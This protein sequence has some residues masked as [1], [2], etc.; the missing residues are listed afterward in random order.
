MSKTFE[1]NSG[2]AGDMDDIGR[3][4]Q[5]AG[6]R[7]TIPSERLEK[8]RHR[9]GAHWEQVVAEQRRGGMTRFR[10]VAVAAS[11]LVAVAASFL[12]WRAGDAPVVIV[13]ASID[14]V[15]GE[16]LVA[17]QVVGKGD[18][19]GVDTLIATGP[20]SRIALRMAGGQSLRI[21]TS[22]QLLVHSSNHVFLQASG[23]YIDTD[24]ALNPLP[25]MVSTPLGVA[26]DVGTQFQVR[27]AASVLMVGVRDGV[28]EVAQTGQQSLSVNKDRFVELDMNGKKAERILPTD[29]PSWDWVDTV[30]PEF[31]IQGVS[32]QKYLTWYAGQRGI[33][34]VWAD[35]A[36]QAKAEGIELAGSIAGTTLHESLLTVQQ[37]APFD[38]RI[39]GDTIWV[40]VE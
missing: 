37:I 2:G 38:Y 36:S 24:S 6:A 5:Y 31:D 25:I 40:K 20:D 22:S 13:S 35:D 15:L 34:L 11:V 33:E 39:E 4:I 10:Y 12:L 8:A 7:D 16:V 17:D 18:V 19:I 27:L 1:K 23:V 26:R 9:V 14:R 28:V 21:D 32:L 29:D 3:L 30:A